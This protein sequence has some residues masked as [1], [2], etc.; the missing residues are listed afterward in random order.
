MLHFRGWPEVCRTKFA[1][2][3]RQRLGSPIK[4]YLINQYRKK[5]CLGNPINKY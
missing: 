1:I 4:K 2:P 3:R 5:L